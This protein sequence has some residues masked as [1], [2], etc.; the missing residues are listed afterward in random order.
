[1]TRITTLKKGDACLEVCE[2]GAARMRITESH[3]VSVGPKWI[4]ATHGKY[5]HEGHGEYGW[6]LFLSKEDLAD[7]LEHESLRSA[8]HRESTRGMRS[9]S[10]QDLRDAAKILGLEWKR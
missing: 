6:S 3:I 9:A 2:P 1:M 4:T 8:F 10:L 5:N 7:S